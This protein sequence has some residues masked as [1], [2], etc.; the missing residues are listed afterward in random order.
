MRLILIPGGHLDDHDGASIQEEHIVHLALAAGSPAGTTNSHLLLTFKPHIVNGDTGSASELG[1]AGL[2]V[3]YRS[4]DAK[5]RHS[6]VG[7]IADGPQCASY[8]P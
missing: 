7:P 6:A 4:S 2:N 1:P 3:R 5:S 8:R